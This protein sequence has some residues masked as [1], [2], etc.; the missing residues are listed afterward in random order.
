MQVHSFHS[1]FEIV[2]IYRYCQIWIILV[3]ES[4]LLRGVRLD[5]FAIGWVFQCLDVLNAW[6]CAGEE[7]FVFFI[8]WP[9]NFRATFGHYDWATRCLARGAFS[10]LSIVFDWVS[11]AFINWEVL[12][13][14]FV[15]GILRFS[16]DFKPIKVGWMFM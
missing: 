9:L 7:I 11:D 2:V 3:N 14:C 13:P 15:L 6:K 4:A 10:A 1:W 5:R 16:Y 12:D 8:E